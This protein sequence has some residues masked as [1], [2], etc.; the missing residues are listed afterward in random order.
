[1]TREI[2][3]RPHWSASVST[4]YMVLGL[5]WLLWPLIDAQH[6]PSM[7]DLAVE[8]PAMVAA[9]TT[10]LVLLAVARWI[11]DSRTLE[12][13]GMI[14]AMVLGDIIVRVAM[15]PGR[16]GV[17]PVFVL[18]FLAGMA[19]GPSAGILVGGAGA[20][21]STPVVGGV[22][23]VLPGQALVWAVVGAMGGIVSGMRR[24]P[25]LAVGIVLAAISGPVA[26]VLLDAMTWFSEPSVELDGFF[27]GLGPLVSFQRL[28]IHAYRTSFAVDGVRGV[29]T[30]L[31]VGVL[32]PLVL[33]GLRTAWGWTDNRVDESRR[34]VERH[35]DPAQVRRREQIDDRRRSCTWTS[36]DISLPRQE[37]R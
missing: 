18:P 34:V 13:L 15:S 31:G 27:P 21:L 12:R 35:V 26:G 6:V 1:M 5:G 29:V 23:S 9:S 11:D 4:V 32:G 2:S 36:Q 37:S 28:L 20:L 8:A 33:G 24:R 25:A 16:A 14:T 7:Q 17:E 10:L 22:T 19:W 30:A 3:R